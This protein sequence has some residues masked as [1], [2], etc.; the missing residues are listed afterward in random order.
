MAT[1]CIE[2]GVKLCQ[3]SGFHCWDVAWQRPAVGHPHS[4]T[5]Y[6]YHLKGSSSLCGLTDP[7]IGHSKTAETNYEPTLSNIPDAPGPQEYS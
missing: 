4:G 5:I 7:R 6:R 2:R 1:N 3:I